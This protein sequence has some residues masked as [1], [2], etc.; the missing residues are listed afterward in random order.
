[1][2][3]EA[4]YVQAFAL[5]VTRQTATTWLA[6]CSALP[7]TYLWYS[8][9]LSIEE[10]RSMA[11]E[12][13][14]DWI[15][16]ERSDRLVRAAPCLRTERWPQCRTGRCLSVESSLELPGAERPVLSEKPL[17][18][19]TTVGPDAISEDEAIH[20]SSLLRAAERAVGPEDDVLVPS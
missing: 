13:R 9:K 4:G 15:V 19:P 17:R 5:A 12:G 11:H 20:R 14:P 6:I 16:E 1:M 8:M 2:R 18:L 7:E 10:R 3:C